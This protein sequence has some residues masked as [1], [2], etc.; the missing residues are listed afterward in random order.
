M[1]I[2]EFENFVRLAHCILIYVYSMFLSAGCCACAYP[3]KSG[4]VVVQFIFY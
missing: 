3:E 4:Q 1:K 2:L